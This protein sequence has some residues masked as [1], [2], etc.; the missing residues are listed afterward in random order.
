MP[1]NDFTLAEL[2]QLSSFCIAANAVTPPSPTAYVGYTQAPQELIDDIRR[3]A[4]DMYAGKQFVAQETG[5]PITPA[6]ACSTIAV[7]V[8]P[9]IPDDL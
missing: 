2:E 3:V 8:Y 4:A 6:E 9:Y 7:D 5:D 1:V